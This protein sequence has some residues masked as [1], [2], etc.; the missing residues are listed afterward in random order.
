[1]MDRL[2]EAR[3]C[4][5]CHFNGLFGRAMR[6]DPRVVSANGHDREI[7]LSTSSQVCETVRHCGITRENDAPS[8]SLEQITIVATISVALFSRAPVVH[9]ESDDIDLAGCGPNTLGFSPIELCDLAKAC[10][11]QQIARGA[12]S[13]HARVFVKTTER[14]Q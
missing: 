11:S 13:D 12:R 8:V 1:M 7:D 6:A 3:A 4:R 5:V 2:D 10:S 14:S 9:T